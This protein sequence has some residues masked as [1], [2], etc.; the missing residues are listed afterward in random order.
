M[1]QNEKD[2]GFLV[3]VEISK[4]PGADRTVAVGVGRSPEVAGSGAN[5][6]LGIALG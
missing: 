4:R 6:V 1:D 5:I 2:S 3:I